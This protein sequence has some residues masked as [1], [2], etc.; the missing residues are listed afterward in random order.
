MLPAQPAPHLRLFAPA[1]DGGETESMPP[2]LPAAGDQPANQAG[3]T[4]AEI[5]A[6]YIAHLEGRQAGDDL[7]G[8]SLESSR[9]DLGRFVELY[10]ARPGPSMRTADLTE[11]LASNPR[12]RANATKRRVLY[13]VL[14]MF[15]WADDDAGL[16]SPC[17]VRRPRRL[18]LPVA[19][20]REA[21]VEEY[22]AVMRAGLPE[23][24]RALFFLRRTG[25]RT[26]E[27]REVEWADVDFAAGVLTLWRHKTHR[28]T[29][30]PRMIGLEPCT[31]RLLRN[32]RRRASPRTLGDGKVF[33]NCSGRPWKPAAFALHL[34]RTLGK[35]GIDQGA[36]KRLTA[37]MFR[38][39]WASNA[40]E[41][42]LSDREAADGLGQSGTGLVSWYSKARQ[43]KGYLRKIAEKAVKRQRQPRRPPRPATGDQPSLFPEGG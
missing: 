30:Q 22:I 43:R 2:P 29:G 7:A 18:R 12:W 23:L 20:R 15:R 17:P 41:N 8:I 13:E 9:R 42:A 6:R 11:F 5:V 35:A 40:S 10:G 24:R 39:H 19:P 27:M 38:H 28:V 4:M 26:C 21:T 25:A 3:P 37:Y 16:L 1:D 33:L 34:R 32:M 14:A 31:L 36:G